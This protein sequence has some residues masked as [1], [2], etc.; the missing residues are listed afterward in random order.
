MPLKT[1]LQ[2]KSL[3]RYVFFFIII[4]IIITYFLICY[5]I[6]L[7][8]FKLFRHLENS[9]SQLYVRVVTSLSP[10]LSGSVI[11]EQHFIKCIQIYIFLSM[12]RFYVFSFSLVKCYQ[13]RINL[14]TI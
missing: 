6:V 5:N 3:F 14:I 11:S 10:S 9:K 7:K 1:V 8:G 13:Y 4:I 12:S 2:N